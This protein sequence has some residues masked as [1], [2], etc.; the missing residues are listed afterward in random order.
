M[1]PSSCLSWHPSSN[2]FVCVWCNPSRPHLSTFGPSFI[3]VGPDGGSRFGRTLR[4]ILSGFGRTNFGQSWTRIVWLRPNIRCESHVE[5][6][7]LDSN[8]RPQMSAYQQ[9]P[10]S[11][12]QVP[13]GQSQAES[14]RRRV[15]GR[16][17]AASSRRSA[18]GGWTVVGGQSQAAR[19]TGPGRSHA[20][21][22]RQK[23]LSSQVV[24]ATCYRPVAGW[25]QIATRSFGNT[26]G[27]FPE[28]W[29]EGGQR[30][31]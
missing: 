22:R 3:N 18:K 2:Y 28:L 1:Q 21:S 12:R 10:M 16:Q 30:G 24:A 23:E 17:E 26:I 14:S 9:V 8:Q 15:V 20:V 13:G 4:P 19:S 27:G 11:R 7:L 29:Q 6:K 5:P 31:A 25:G